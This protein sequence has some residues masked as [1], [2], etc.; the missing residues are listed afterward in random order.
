MDIKLAESQVAN[1]LEYLQDMDKK[2]PL[3][4][5]KSKDRLRDVATNCL[6][7]VKVISSILQD[8]TL[9]TDEYEFSGSRRSDIR[10]MIDSMDKEIQKMKNFVG[11]GLNSEEDPIGVETRK[12]ILKLYESVFASVVEK[13]LV[14]QHAMN[15]AK[16]IQEWYTVRFV[17]SSN[18]YPNFRYNIRR[19]KD[20][21][22]GIVILYGRYH[23]SGQESISSVFDSWFNTLSSPSGD[24][25][26]V[27]YQVY[28]ITK[29]LES[30][31]ITLSSLVI[32]DILCHEGYS[33]LCNNG[34]DL[35]PRDDELYELCVKNSP[36]ILDRYR[37]YL[38]DNSVLTECNL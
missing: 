16:I 3:L 1:L 8:E 36:E 38:F 23:E 35:V 25:Y 30:Q 37:N 17:D 26:A 34:G 32:W 7:V 18:K 5:R 10:T 2:K 4:Y 12:S 22:L 33:T 28:T 21:T 6:Q 20:W 19:L 14:S 15:C 11:Y 31:P 13:N 24:R 9:T 27:P 29:D